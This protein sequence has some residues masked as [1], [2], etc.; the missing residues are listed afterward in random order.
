MNKYFLKPWSLSVL[1]GILLYICWP[2]LPFPFIIFFAFVPVLWLTEIYL[3]KYNEYI[4][5]KDS[6]LPKQRFAWK[7]FGWTYICFLIWNIL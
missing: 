1:G 3:S 7:Y 2:P 5:N 6:N 4:E